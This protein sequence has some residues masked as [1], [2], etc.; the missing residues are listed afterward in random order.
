MHPFWNFIVEL[1]PRWLAPNLLTFVGFLCLI[2]NFLLFSIYD[3]SF[4]GYCANQEDCVNMQN[5]TKNQLYFQNNM[6]SFE[7]IPSYICSCIPQWLWMVL[8]ICQFL[9]HHLGNNKIILNKKI[10]K[11]SN[12]RN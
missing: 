11:I 7:T 10:E 8:S 4:Y 6:N 12:R 5:L 1:Y 9:S 3:Y 2:V